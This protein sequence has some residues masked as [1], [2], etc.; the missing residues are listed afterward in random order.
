MAKCHNLGS[1][2]GER[3]AELNVELRR[4]GGQILLLKKNSSPFPYFFLS[5]SARETM[6]VPG[7]TWDIGLPHTNVLS[8]PIFAWP[9]HTC[10]FF[11]CLFGLH[12]VMLRAYSRSAQG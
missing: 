1:R 2:I 10:I 11:V 6:N 12:S 8:S 7:N 5:D 9:G 3:I 4:R